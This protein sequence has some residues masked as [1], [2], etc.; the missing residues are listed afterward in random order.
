MFYLC[1]IKQKYRQKIKIRKKSVI[2][3]LLYIGY[4]FITYIIKSHIHDQTLS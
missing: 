1:K 2:L 4:R 3:F